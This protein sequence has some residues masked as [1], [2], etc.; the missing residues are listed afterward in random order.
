MRPIE[1]G[2]VESLGETSNVFYYKND[3]HIHESTRRK[4]SLQGVAPHIFFSLQKQSV[5]VLLK[6]PLNILLLC[7]PVAII[8]FITGGSAM[9]T[10]F[11]ALL[12]IAPVAER[13]GYLTEQLTFYTSDTS[14][15]LLNITFGNATEFLLSISAL[16]RGLMTLVRL[17][18]LGSIL[19]NLLLV[20]GTSFILNGTLLTQLQ[21][22][23]YDRYTAQINMTL[24][25]IA[26]S[27]VLYP[28]IMS[29]QNDESR[30][31]ENG[32]SRGSSVV[33]IFFYFALLYFQL[34][35]HK[36]MYG[37]IEHARNES[38][39]RQVAT[40]DHDEEDQSFDKFHDGLMTPP[41][42]AA[43]NN[44]RP[45]KSNIHPDL[46][47]GY[48]ICWLVVTTTA[49]AALSECVADSI[50]EAA[51]DAGISGV[52]ISAVLIPIAANAAEHYS[53]LLFSSKG[54]LDL[55]LNVAIG[56]SLQ[57]ALCVIPLL[58]LVGWI[59]GEDMTLN[60]GRFEASTMFMAVLVMAIAVKDGEAN[61]LLGIIITGFYLIIAFGFLVHKNAPLD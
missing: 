31:G 2:E 22:R 57:I 38:T 6:G 12:A 28:T 46:S 43:S 35:T 37:N 7:F 44:S 11:C 40:S 30:I 13:L 25:L 1:L 47:F 39:Y 33:L 48:T 41:P 10:C 19:S 45:I 4:R 42:T 20:I 58:V 51:K 29:S 23:S 49:V 55:A 18:L 61:Y 32:L 26:C 36:H 34:V 60:F 24:L 53:A 16:K 15:A 9:L 21:D 27:A 17:S 14:S 3:H 54:K 5:T 50:E 56:S 59:M 8:S 52:F